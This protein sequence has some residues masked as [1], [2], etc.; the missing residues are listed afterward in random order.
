[1]KSLYLL[2]FLPFL[3]VSMQGQALVFVE[4]AEL[5]VDTLTHVH[6]EGGINWTREGRLSNRGAIHLGSTGRGFTPL[7]ADWYQDHSTNSGNVP[8]TNGQV[9]FEGSLTPHRI[10]GAD[11]LAFS[12]VVLRNSA[13]S[14]GILSLSQL[15][16][17][18]ASLIL[19]K[20]KLYIYNPDPSGIVATKRGGIVGDTYPTGIGDES[21]TQVVWEMGNTS[22]GRRFKVPFLTQQGTEIPF[23]FT[24]AT[25][26]GDPVH[27]FTYPTN[28]LNEPYPVALGEISDVQHLLNALGEDYSPSIVDRY[29][30]LGGGRNTFSG[31]SLSFDSLDV[32]EEVRGK[33]YLLGGQ[34][35]NGVKWAYYQLGDSIGERS[36]SWQSPLS[37]SGIWS[38]SV[39]RLPTSQLNSLNP[40]SFTLSPNPTT[41]I[42]Q[43]GLSL[44]SPKLLSFKLYNGLGK[45]V[46][47]RPLSQR[48]MNIEL[49][50][51]LRT[52]S[53]GVYHFIV[54]SEK[55]QAQRKILLR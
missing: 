53:P 38:L 15:M 31:M 50:L 24:L 30:Y 9:Y 11:S 34:W 21:Y 18:S 25:Y 5:F 19:H 8:G 22:E 1:M 37:A 40:L 43:V 16:L 17:D 35:W 39:S 42:C 10:W 47:E 46:W 12:G 27:T 32:S 55:E 3:P 36:V 29:W 33:E 6:V 41:G 23:E 13:E 49:E 28:S 44:D 7:F 2:C 45:L 54:Y 26:Q 51:D 4:G 52:Y 48:T 14:E 20:K